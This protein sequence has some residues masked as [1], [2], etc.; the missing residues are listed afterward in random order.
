MK[1][2]GNKGDGSIFLGQVTLEF[3]LVFVIMVALLAGLL[4]LWKWSSDNIIKRQIDY[5]STRAAA[6]QISAAEEPPATYEAQQMTEK[7]VYLFK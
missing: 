4:S 5:N 1:N 7:D 6:G 2:K 3:T